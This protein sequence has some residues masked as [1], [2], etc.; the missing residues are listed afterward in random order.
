MKTS[1][2]IAFFG[3]TFDP[4]HEG[5]LEIAHKA[6][7]ELH[8]DQILFI[9]CRQSPHKNSEPGASDDDRL[10]MLKLATA[11]LPWA[12]VHPYELMQP[13]PSYTWETVRHF[14]MEFSKRTALFLLIGDDQWA[15][16]P[17]WKNVETLAED[18]EFIIVGRNRQPSPRVGF[19]A[20]FINGDHPASSSEIRETLHRGD[21]PDWLPAEV[22]DYISKKGLYSP[23][24]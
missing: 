19:Q 2:R 17:L 10:E 6:I 14:K 12:I 9:P 15:A 23:T 20:H 16:L 18:V 4:I 11:D 7:A 1:K 24:P 8:L 13:P 3:G 22:A 21:R 5:H